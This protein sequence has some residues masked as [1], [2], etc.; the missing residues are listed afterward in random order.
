M[1]S[2]LQTLLD[3]AGLDQVPETAP[4]VSFP[5]RRSISYTGEFRRI[6]ALPR[7]RWAKD[8]LL[9]KSIIWFLNSHF[10]NGGM[11]LWPI[12]AAAINDIVLESGAFLPIGV[13]RGKA[14]ISLLTP[15]ALGAKRPVLFVP[16]A[17]RD[18]TNDYVIP[19]MKKHWKLDSNLKVVGYSELSLAKNANMLEEL[20]PDLIILDECHRVSRVQAGRTK[21]LVR[22]FRNHPETLC[23]AMSGTVSQRSL[24]DFGHIIGWCL[25]DNAPLPAPWRE[26]A[27]WADA[28]DEKVPDV[29]RAAPGA[30]M[31]FCQDGENARQ[32]FRRRL[33]ETP[34]VVATAESELGTSL[35]VIRY[36]DLQIPPRIASM[37]ETMRKTWTTPNGDIIV[38]AVDLWRHVRELALG[39]W[40]RWDPK[41]PRDW[42][43][44][45]KKWKAYVRE[46]LKHNR[47]GLDTELQVWNECA[48]EPEQKG[49]ENPVWREWREIK[50][51]FKPNTVPVWEDKFAAIA[52]EKWILERHEKGET[53]IVWTEHQAFGEEFSHIYFG[54]GNSHI[55]DTQERAIVASV[56]AHSEGKNLERFSKNLV[57]APMT[58]GK[59][60]EQLLGRTHREGQKADTVTCEVFLHVPELRASFDQ[61]R[62]DAVYLE[63]TSGNR[64]KLNY[65]DVVI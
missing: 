5:S 62:A 33:V 24:K 60:W 58:S 29:Q 9:P 22:W 8:R 19:E 11:K 7:R 28:L 46:T 10:G 54:A 27:E 52:V 17:L 12:Q 45:R 26:L 4:L 51:T 20:Q 3:R 32:G 55:L 37:L 40:Y 56:K 53:G 50:D 31:R 43:D 59:A 18:Q 65:A 30:L 36:Q 64:Q 44:A 39:F 61:A 49:I 14:L 25:K 16:A 35:R 1:T 21:R 47:R 15:V 6:E 2:L 23:V 13:G 42:L 63:D 38:N 41:P 57:V 34:G 48:K